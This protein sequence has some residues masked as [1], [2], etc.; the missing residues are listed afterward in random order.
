MP[1]IASAPISFQQCHYQLGHLCGFRLSYSV[2]QGILGLSY[3]MSAC[4]NVSVVQLAN[5][6]NR[7]ILS[8]QWVSVSTSFFTWFIL[9]YD[10]ERGAIVTMLYLLMTSL[11]ILGFTL[12][13]VAATY[14]RYIII[15]LPW[16]I[17]SFHACSCV[18]TWFCLQVVLSDVAWLSCLVWYSRSVL[19]SWSSRSDGMADRKYHPFFRQLMRWWS[20]PLF[21]LT[22]WVRLYRLPPISSISSVWMPCRA[23][24]L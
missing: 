17:L 3:A 8:Y 20:P 21:R 9:M 16:F 12:W 13:I 10:L 19:L 6:L 4:Y 7:L 22:F 1:S 11:T 5:S 15:L 14:S 23:V 18:L 24:F 2:H